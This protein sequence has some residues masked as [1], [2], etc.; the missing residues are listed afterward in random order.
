M[1]AL[2]GI[3]VRIVAYI[4]SDWKYIRITDINEL[5]DILPKT[6]RKED[7][8]KKIIF[9]LFLFLASIANAFAQGTNKPEF[10]GNSGI[11]FPIGPDEFSDYWRM[12]FNF[13]GGIGY[14]ISPNLS[15]VGYFD[16]N[17]F[18]FDDD[19]YL[20]D[21]GFAGYGIS[22]SGGEASIIT[23]SGNL[24]ATLHT[25]TSS[26]HPYLW[27]GIGF[28]KLSIGDITIY[29]PG[30]AVSVEGDSESAFSVLVGGG[31]DFVIGE[32]MDLFIE[33]KYVIGFTEGESTQMFPV[34]FG[35]KFR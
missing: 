17:N 26:V 22:I 13:G 3:Y 20:R 31:I 25:T 29:G 28:F 18:R 32:R 6:K 4:P 2:R 9:G 11:S 30:G 34:K 23:L 1:I 5:D 15:L 24:K 21:Y 16:F 10:Y 7:V 8:M 12:G 19:K 27:G 35:I 33:G 14:P